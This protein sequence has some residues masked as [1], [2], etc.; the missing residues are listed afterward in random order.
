[1]SEA[2]RSEVESRAEAVTP[3]GIRWFPLVWFSALLLI[4]YAVVLA[5]TARLWVDDLNMS[6]GMFVPILV[7]YIVWQERHALRAARFSHDRSGLVLMVIGAAL[8][9]MGPPKLDTFAF[10]TRVGFMFSLTGTILYLCGF[11]TIRLLAYPL[12]LLFMM[13]PLPGFVLERFTLPLQLTASKLAEQLLEWFGYSVMRDGNILQ[14]PGQTLSIAEACSGLRSLM[15]LTFLAQAYV[16]MFDKRPWMRLVIAICVVPIAVF[17]NGARIVATA[18]A[19]SYRKEW[20]EGTFHESTAWVVF[21]VTFVCI[22][23]THRLI[24]TVHRRSYSKRSQRCSTT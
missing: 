11:A 18:I 24:D 23:V 17:A 9:C 16:Y 22:V 14:L 13:F 7:A 3:P 21:A 5:R 1:M 19:G 12:V 6:H 15:A 20:A 2:V 4:A 10:A 8:L